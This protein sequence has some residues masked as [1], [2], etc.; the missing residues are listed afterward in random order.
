MPYDADRL[1]KEDEEDEDHTDTDARDDRDGEMT[2]ESSDDGEMTNE[3]SYTDG[4][5]PSDVEDNTVNVGWFSNWIGNDTA[6]TLKDED[7]AAREDA[8]G[9]VANAASPAGWILTQ[10]TNYFADD[11]LK[12]DANGFV[13][14][15]EE[16]EEGGGETS[17]DKRDESPKDI[18]DCHTSHSF[19]GQRGISSNNSTKK[20]GTSHSH[21]SFTKSRGGGRRSS[22]FAIDSSLVRI[23]SDASYIMCRE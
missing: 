17:V 14:E 12:V 9:K 15:V 13:T 7:D 4:T 16:E 10:M 6:V 3:E 5:Y 11:T 1:D 22:S 8:D 19:R 20:S 23:S 2:D 21:K 18:R